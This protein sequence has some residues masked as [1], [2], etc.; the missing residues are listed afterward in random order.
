MPYSFYFTLLFLSIYTFGNAERIPWTTSQIHGSP[1][2]PPAYRAEVI[3]PHISFTNGLDI[4]L[5]E[6]ENKLFILEQY[7]KI[8]WLPADLS[9]QPD[10]ATP[11]GDLRDMIPDLMNALGLAFHPDFKKTREAFIYYNTEDHGGFRMMRASRFKLDSDLQLLPES[12]EDLFEFKGQGHVGG[13]IQFGPDGM[14]YISVGDLAAPSPPDRYDMGQDLAKWGSKILRIDVR[15]NDPGLPYHIPDDNPF[16]DIPDARPETWAYGFRN[17]WKFSFHPET[18]NIWTGD[19]GW[20]AWEM[21]YRVEKGNNF[22]WP[23]MEGPVPLRSDLAQGPTPIVPPTAYYSHVEGASIT[24]G[25]FV[26]SSRIPELQGAYLYG[27]YITGRVWALYWDGQKVTR[28]DLIADTRK[29]IVTFG[30]DPEGDLIFLDYPVDGQLHR[31][32]PAEK[33]SQPNK[34]PQSLSESGLFSDVIKEVPSPGVYPFSINAPTWQD[35]LESRYWIGLP[36]KGSIEAYVNYREEI[37]LMGYRQPTDTVLAKTIHNNGKRI[38][39]QILHFDGYW[40]GYSYRWNADQTDAVLV[41]KEGLDTIIDEKPYHFPARSECVRCH[42]SNFNRPLAFYPGQIDRDGQLDRFR[43]LDLVNNEFLEA[44]TFQKAANPM[45]ETAP[46]NTRA[47]SWIH[48]NCAHCHRVSGGAGVTS[49]MNLGVPNER[50]ELILNEPMKGNFGL[51]N[52][53]LI[54]PGNPYR[55]I[56]Y[57]RINTLGAGHMPMIGARTMDENGIELIHDWI[58]SMAPQKAIPDPTL[59]P[60]NV[61]QALALMHRIR[62]G[63]LPKAEAQEAISNCLKSSDPFIINLFAGFSLE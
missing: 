43:A 49:M 52:G 37:P 55:S 6:S 46:L 23:I 13:D 21:V 39:T 34:F 41:P 5:L 62:T 9:A 54:E 57:Y 42:G 24:G 2:P 47:R 30:Q 18:G 16:L 60:A 33:R 50:T 27:D 59:K 12:R 7:G 35:G 29:T 25:Y 58:R 53:S 32:V 22:G 44:A 31:L 36:G 51:E 3:W 14:L 11:A 56:L 38:E 8:W 63:A 40:N 26:T 17:P 10:A 15:R 48:A 28:N 19:V 45:D 20:E 4:T 61:E 1:E